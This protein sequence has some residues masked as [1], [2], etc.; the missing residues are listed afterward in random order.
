MVVP[1]PRDGFGFI[2]VQSRTLR[3]N[4]GIANSHNTR[5]SEKDYPLG[6]EPE[7]RI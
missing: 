3:E 2:N 4:S 5:L 6:I 1:S 7:I